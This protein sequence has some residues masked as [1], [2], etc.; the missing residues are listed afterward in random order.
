VVLCNSMLP[1]G[2]NWQLFRP[3]I[4]EWARTLK[5]VTKYDVVIA[6]VDYEVPQP[7][8]DGGS[9]TTKVLA[10]VSDRPERDAHN[11]VAR[12]MYTLQEKMPWM[13][14]GVFCNMAGL[15][16]AGAISAS[17]RY[18][19]DRT[20]ACLSQTPG[21]VGS[22]NGVR[23]DGLYHEEDPAGGQDVEYTFVKY[24]C[25]KDSPE[26]CPAF[27]KLSLRMSTALLTIQH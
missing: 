21:S 1:K 4:P 8:N 17:L 18:A 11:L 6:L 2:N 16:T 27:R 7:G 23:V 9:V 20:D 3:I 10:K 22:I 5:R 15:K 24:P 26:G 13:R 12:L 25:S 19:Q 14:N